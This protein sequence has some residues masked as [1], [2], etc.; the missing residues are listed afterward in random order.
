[1]AAV[2]LAAFP[3]SAAGVL[4]GFFKGRTNLLVPYTTDKTKTVSDG[5]LAV[6]VEQAVVSK[7]QAVIV[8]SL[9]IYDNTKADWLSELT[10]YYL[11]VKCRLKDGSPISSFNVFDIPDTDKFYI[12]HWAV[13]AAG[14]DNPKLEPLEFSLD[15]IDLPESERTIEIEAKAELATLRFDLHTEG[16]RVAV[17]PIGVRAILPMPA[18]GIIPNSFNPGI[19]FRM[20]DGQI[21][22]YNRLFSQCRT[23]GKADESGQRYEIGAISKE[24]MLLSD[25]KSVIVNGTEYYADGGASKAEIPENL[26]RQTFALNYCPYTKS[27]RDLDVAEIFTRLGAKTGWSPNKRWFTVEYND[28]DAKIYVGSKRVILGDGSHV[29]L[30]HSAHIINGRLMVDSGFI[31]SVIPLNVVVETEPGP[32][33]DGEALSLREVFAVYP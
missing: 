33:S 23:E 1:M 12:R 3:S 30:A 29:D 25:F 5:R 6:T 22:S 32:S 26:R 31:Y 21:K 28:I 11:G 17:S 10:P 7:E 8:F 24:P 19:Y 18:D 16:C 2:F 15:I 13:V 20:S 14:V 9:Q 27:S 4:Q